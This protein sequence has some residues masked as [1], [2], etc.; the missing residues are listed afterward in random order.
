MRAHSWTL[1]GRVA[2]ATLALFTLLAAPLAAQAKPAKPFKATMTGIDQAFLDPTCS[3][4]LGSTITGS[5]NATHLGIFTASLRDCVTI[6]N[7]GLILL[8]GTFVAVAADGSELRGT[9]E[10]E[11]RATPTTEQDGIFELDGTYEILTGTKRFQGATGSGVFTG[12]D[13]V[14]TNAVT[15]SLDGVLVTK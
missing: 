12:T 2:V 11:L 8:E 7:P 9:Y 15:L 14:I 6:V 3:T 4:G 5:G 1:C 10:G 13:S